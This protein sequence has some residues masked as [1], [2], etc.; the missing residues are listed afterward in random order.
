MKIAIVYFGLPR[1]SALCMP[2]IQ[3]QVYDQMPEEASVVS[4]YH[5]YVQSVVDNP[6]SGEKGAFDQSNYAAFADMQ[7]ALEAP[8]DCLT[9]WDFEGIKRYGDTWKD[10]FKSI[11]NLVHQLH[12][13]REVTHSVRKGDPDV[14]IFLRPD[15]IYHDPLPYSALK[16][17]QKHPNAV[18]IPH[19]QWWNG[20][21]DRFA[22]C[23]RRAYDAY[24]E[25]LELAKR[26]CET[27]QRPL[28]SERLLK[29][30]L[31]ASKASLRALDVRASRVR[32]DGQMVDETFSR[33]RSMGKRQNR[34]T[35]PAARLR[36][37][38]DRL[39]YSDK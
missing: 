13:L 26:F 1:N 22:I 37:F 4:H 10:G 35:L 23:G 24:G 18:Y 17:C 30:A 5:F 29:Y 27:Q 21:N 34:F 3:A 9:Q 12:S 32:I 11:A 15:L 36:A 31:H 39:R 33:K 19:W 7:G 2:S 28:N 25:R 16:A 14:V 6:R 38:A 20:L 8:G